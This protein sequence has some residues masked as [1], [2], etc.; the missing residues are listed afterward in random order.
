MG[1]RHGGRNPVTDTSVED[2]VERSQRARIAVQRF[3]RCSA[4]VRGKANQVEPLGPPAGGDR[5]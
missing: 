3:L 4:S 5:S 1:M 2:R